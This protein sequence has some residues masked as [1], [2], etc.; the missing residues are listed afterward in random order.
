MRSIYE[1]VLATEILLRRPMHAK[2]QVDSFM[3]K[4][5]DTPSSPLME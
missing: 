5:E 2:E 4:G 1:L 3:A